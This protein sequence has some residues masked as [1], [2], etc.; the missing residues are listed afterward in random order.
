MALYAVT[1]GATEVTTDVN[2]Y[3]QLVTG[4]MTDQAVTLANDLTAQH[5]VKLGSSAPVA[6]GPDI[7]S[8]GTNIYV[9]TNGAG[10]ISL[11]PNGAGSATNQAN[12]DSTG[13]LTVAGQVS[14]ASVA[15]SGAV[16]GTS[17]TFTGAVQSNSHPVVEGTS[18][19]TH[20]EV[21]PAQGSTSLASNG[22]V[23][24]TLTFAR[25]FASNPAVSASAMNGGAIVPNAQW[26]PT[27]I[28]TSSV[29]FIF[30]NKDGNPQTMTN[31]SI[32]ALGA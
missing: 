12:Y 1:A 22:T 21:Y 20:A 14:A 23:S 13:H 28:S 25:A 29:T 18:A 27:A 9:E 15:S 31:F 32:S 4:A 8:D 26:Q 19:A 11:R 7:H 16:S 10:T 2:Q 5:G 24:F 3:Y 17:G 30:V 6:S